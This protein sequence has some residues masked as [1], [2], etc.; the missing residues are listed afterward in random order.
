[1][2]QKVED[3]KNN[4]REAGM[5]FASLAL[6][7]KLAA[8]DGV[9]RRSELAYC[10]KFFS[11]QNNETDLEAMITWAVK[12]VA[13]PEHYSRRIMSFYP[14]K[15]EMFRSL[16]DSLFYLAA[17]DGPINV[18]EIKFLRNISKE[19]GFCEEFFVE[20]LKS[21]IIP[22]SGSPYK[23]ISVSRSVK[24]AELKKAYYKAVQ[25][26]H[27]DK[28]SSLQNAEEIIVLANYRVNAVNDAYNAIKKQKKF[29]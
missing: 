13:S 17:I 21:H 2:A 9:I 28:L 8:I 10:E 18:Q 16:I 24:E 20:K 27:P 3:Y 11:R 6:A 1:M 12:D 26:Y 25:A 5:R 29:R 7:A 4:V 22:P 14:C 23:V 19:F 15:E